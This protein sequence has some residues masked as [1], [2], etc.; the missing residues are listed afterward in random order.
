MPKRWRRNYAAAAAGLSHLCHATVQ[1]AHR[2][3]VDGAGEATQRRDH[4]RSLA[5]QTFTDED[6]GVVGRHDGSVVLEAD[7]VERRLAAAGRPMPVYLFM[8]GCSGPRA[9]VPGDRLHDLDDAE[10]R[11]AL[12]Y[13]GG[14]PE[15][16]LA[17]D[18]LMELLAP[19]LRADFGVAKTWDFR[20]GPPLAC[21]ITGL[22]GAVDPIASPAQMQGSACTPSPTGTSSSTPSAPP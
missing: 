21:P 22:A 2:R 18:A 12:R 4:V 17:D 14:T 5:S 13:H 19:L 3:V 16:V 20:A 11:A 10:F 15:A 1:L 6:D 9:H 7:E 8:S